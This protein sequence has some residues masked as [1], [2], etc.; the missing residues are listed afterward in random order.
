MKSYPKSEQDWQ[1]AEELGAKP[2]MLK[3]LLLN[4]DYTGWS[5][6][7]DDFYRVPGGEGWSSHVFLG[8]WPEFKALWSP[9]A[10]DNLIASFHFRIDRD[11][12]H[13][14]ACGGLGAHADAQWVTRSW[15]D[16]ESPF[17]PPPPVL[18]GE[19][20]AAFEALLRERQKGGVAPK[21]R[22]SQAA[23]VADI[24]AVDPSLLDEMTSSRGT[25]AAW[26]E[27]RKAFLEQE[28]SG[29]SRPAEGDSPEV[30]LEKAKIREFA[31]AMLQPDP[32][33]ARMLKAYGEPFRQH[34]IAALRNGGTW[35]MDLTQDEVDALWE[36]QRLGLEF[37]ERPTA[38]QVNLRA[39]EGTLHHDGLNQWYCTRRR[40]ERLGIPFDCP[41]CKG[42]GQV[43]AAPEPTLEL[44]LWALHPR[45]GASRGVVIKGIKEE[46]V[47]LAVR[48]L[49]RAAASA[50]KKVWGGISLKKRK[51]EEAQCRRNSKSGSTS[52]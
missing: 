7:D 18:L 4:P 49:R 48:W 12:K 38:E 10:N 52:R 51:K 34:C 47:R 46:E 13:C 19:Q 50:A 39:K 15:W 32:D 3:A 28:A 43:W 22:R 6:G 26:R 33:L 31:A 41:G 29:M 30:A 36:K 2:W 23:G 8:S 11:A 5:P 21:V 24:D 16:M 42:T 37:P 45:K 35:K 17:A 1:W 44:V 14:E 27:S 25:V 40:C 20:L 9:D